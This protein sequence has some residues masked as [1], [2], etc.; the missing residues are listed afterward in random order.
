[1]MKR[2]PF[3]G[4]LS[5][6]SPMKGLIEHYMKIDE[7]LN[8]IKD[9]LECYVKGSEVCREFDELSNEIDDIEA[10]AD[11]IKRNIRNHLPRRLFMAVDKTLF[12]NYTRGQDNILDAA[13]EALHWLGMRRMEVPAEFQKPIIDFMDQVSTTAKLLQPALENTVKIVHGEALDR[14]VCKEKFRKI[15]DQRDR[16]SREKKVL[17][18]K[19]YNAELD[20][21]DIYQLILFIECLSEM[22]K[23]CET[24]SDTLRAMIAR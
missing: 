22:A 17:I 14:E 21:K 5:P 10:H 8:I 3:F 12:L 18:S 24:C 19:I 16:V 20:F 7:C 6:R 13:Q 1:M 23:N 9:A 11:K 15:R 4:L 2:L